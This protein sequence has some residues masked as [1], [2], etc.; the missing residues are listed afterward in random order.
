MMRIKSYFVKSIDEAITQARAELGEEALL[1]NTRK[2]AALGEQE[3]GY[4]VVFGADEEA[5]GSTTDAPSEAQSEAPATEQQLI[6]AVLE[7][8]DT[9]AQP[10]MVP[11]A[12]LEEVRV[13]MEEMHRLLLSGGAPP[14]DRRAL[15]ELTGLYR[16]LLDAGFDAGLANDVVGDVEAAVAAE[17]PTMLFKRTLSIGWRRFDTKKFHGIVRDELNSRIRIDPNLGIKGCEKTIVAMAGPSGAGTTATLMKIAAMKIAPDRP[18]RLVSMDAAALGSRMEMQFFARKSGVTFTALEKPEDLPALTASVRDGETMLIDPGVYATAP[19]RERLSKIFKKCLALDVHLVIPGCV[20]ARAAREAIRAYK[21]L[22]PGKLVITK[23]DETPT[24]GAVLTEA[25]R[26]KLAIS[27]L[28]TGPAIPQD[29][30][31]ASVED[32]LSIAVEREQAQQ[33]VCA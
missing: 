24:Y 23:L 20:T 11:Q 5:V 19:H 28:A 4:E 13:Q 26:A 18:V 12:E 29:L 2:I 7:S 31:A 9:E 21:I 1:L 15:P 27:L 14:T 25:S 33:D 17:A 3:G 6:E 8:P 30:R 22:R 32:L 16:K 10:G